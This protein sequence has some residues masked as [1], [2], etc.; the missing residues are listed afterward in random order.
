MELRD[1]QARYNRSPEESFQER[2]KVI[3]DY[4]DRLDETDSPIANDIAADLASTVPL[5]KTVVIIPVAAHQEAAN[6]GRAV[7]EYA[8]QIPAAPFTLV[9]GLNAPFSAFDSKGINATMD[10]VEK[11]KRESPALDMRTTLVRYDEPIIGQV[12]RDLWNGVAVAARH[13]GHFAGDQEVIGINHDIDLIRLSKTCIASVQTHYRQRDKRHLITPVSPASGT[14]VKHAN[15]PAHPNTS[16]AVFWNDF[17]NRQI[18]GTYEAGLVIP[19]SSYAANGG[20]LKTARTN[21]VGQL[22]IVNRSRKLIRGTDTETSP[23]RY[24]AQIE[25]DGY[26]IWSDD[27]F[28]A[29]DECRDQLSFPDIS[30]PRMLD[31]IVGQL[32]QNARELRDSATDKAFVDYVLHRVDYETDYTLSSARAEEDTYIAAR[33]KKAGSLAALILRRLTASDRLV[34]QLQKA[35]DEI[36]SAGR[37]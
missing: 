5:A 37:D 4:L 7:S 30:R 1:I 2:R 10:A 32:D 6:I 3:S 19:M 35:F 11:A 15:S 31:I 36:E 33:T 8:R 18:D 26:D 23:R 20:F 17:V 27:R 9:L 16:R 28:S 21:E 25:H 13:A 14:K 29:Q 22:A 34:K 12:R 24:I